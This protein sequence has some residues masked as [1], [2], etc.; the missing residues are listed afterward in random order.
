MQTIPSRK[1][2]YVASI[3]F[4]L[5]FSIDKN[6]KVAKIPR[7]QILRATMKQLAIF[8]NHNPKLYLKI[9]N[10][11]SDSLLSIKEK[12]VTANIDAREHLKITP[13]G[14]LDSLEF[15]SPG[16][17]DIFSYREKD[18]T[19]L[20]N[21][22]KASNLNFYSLMYAN[23]LLSEI[24]ISLEKVEAMDEKALNAIINN[25][26]YNRNKEELSNVR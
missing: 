17:L 22:Y 9:V 19:A 10:V 4:L 2:V 1:E 15:R 24:D 8:R 26:D 3:I 13:S 12:M 20:S 21:A 6:D 14:L 25:P 5:L 11:A 18:R 23:R 16:I 7:K